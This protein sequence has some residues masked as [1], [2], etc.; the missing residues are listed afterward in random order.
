MYIYIYIL[1]MYVFFFEIYVRFEIGFWGRVMFQITPLAP[2]P[3]NYYLGHYKD[4]WVFGLPQKHV[5][6]F[7]KC[8]WGSKFDFGIRE[9]LQITLWGPLNDYLG[10]KKGDWVLGSPFKDVRFFFFMKNVCIFLK[11]VCFS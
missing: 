5:C 8:I 6:I 4:D 3:P 7:V 10:H 9:R 11:N 1:R 2:P